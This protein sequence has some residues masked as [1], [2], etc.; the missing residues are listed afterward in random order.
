[1][2]VE[3]GRGRGILVAPYQVTAE[4]EERTPLTR[5]CEGRVCHTLLR[6]LE[7]GDKF[8]TPRSSSGQL[9]RP[10]PGRLLLRRELWH[11]FLLRSGAEPGALTTRVNLQVFCREKSGNA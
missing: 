8:N 3:I 10:Y 2:F 11:T 9:D 4:R 5:S 1:M 7:L 6:L